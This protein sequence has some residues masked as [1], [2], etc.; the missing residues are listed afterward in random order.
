MTA[1]AATDVSVSISSRDLDFINAGASTKK[2][3]I[4]DITFGD[5][6]KTYPT[7]GVPL[8]AIGNFGFRRQ[9]AMGVV[10]QPASNGFIYK[11]DRANH[12]IKIFTQGFRTGPTAAAAAE[13]G[14]K[15]TRSDG[16]EIGPRIP[17]T[18]PNSTYDTG[19]MQELLA[20]EAPDEVTLRVLFIGE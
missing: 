12:K 18:A 7:G 11:Y 20:A 5:G 10:E 15:L 3:V 1:L 14:A 6:S 4:A 13:N 19:P 8:P 2:F 16:V 9:I 17:N